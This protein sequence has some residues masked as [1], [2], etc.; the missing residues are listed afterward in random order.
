[1]TCTS[2]GA[3]TISYKRELEKPVKILLDASEKIAD[4]HLD[5]QISFEKN[6][7]IGALCDSFEKMRAALYQSNKETWRMLEERKEINAAFAHEMRTPITVLKGYRDLLEKFIPG[8]AVSEEKIMDILQMMK[9]QIDRLEI[10]TQKMSAMQKLEDIVPAPAEIQVKVLMDKCSKIG[11][12]L[13]NKLQKSGP[14]F[15]KGIA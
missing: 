9:G 15:L 10:H 2:A 11:N 4:N 5:F 12:M 6:N 7:E 8:G 3:G 14:H 13:G 1:M